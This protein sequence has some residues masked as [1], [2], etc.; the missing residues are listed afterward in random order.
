MIW[1]FPRASYSCGFSITVKAYGGLSKTNLLA[2]RARCFGFEA[3]LVDSDCGELL[4]ERGFVRLAQ[5]RSVKLRAKRSS[6]AE[7]LVVRWCSA[8][9]SPTVVVALYV[10]LLGR[11]KL[12]KC[13]LL[14]GEDEFCISSEALRNRK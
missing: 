12:Y 5:L 4:S 14:I 2:E 7:G 1:Y 9:L 6:C 10:I 8:F 13:V 11:M 3:K